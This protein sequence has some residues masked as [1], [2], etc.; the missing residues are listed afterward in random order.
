MGI[1]KFEF[2]PIESFRYLEGFLVWKVREMRTGDTLLFATVDVGSTKVA[3]IGNNVNS[4]AIHV[5]T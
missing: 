5:I 1:S 3:I 2:R 4:S